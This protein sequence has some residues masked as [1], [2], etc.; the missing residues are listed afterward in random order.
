MGILDLFRRKPK[1]EP[2]RRR[3]Y[4]AVNKGRLFADWTEVLVQLTAK[5]DRP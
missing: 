3:S 2:V 4:A 1:P 5:L